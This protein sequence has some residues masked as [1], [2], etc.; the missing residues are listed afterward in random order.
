MYF[1][2]IYTIVFQIAS[3]IFYTSS[4]CGRSLCPTLYFN[5]TWNV[6]T[7]FIKHTISIINY[8]YSSNTRQVYFDTSCVLVCTACVKAQF[9][10]D[11]LY[12]N[13]LKCNGTICIKINL[14]VKAQYVS[15]K[16]KCNGTIC[17]KINL[18][19]EAQYV[20]K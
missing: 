7:S 18:H 15:K 6:S 9:V 17:I 3:F 16:P 13:K 12:Q 11:N 10:K 2:E 8:T 20:S 14:H 5:Q 4:K 1:S 19:I